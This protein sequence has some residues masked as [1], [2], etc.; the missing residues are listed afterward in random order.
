MRV[1]LD[2][3]TLLWWILDDPA[4][5]L[6]ASDAIAE[7]HDAVFVSAATAWELAIKF[8]LGR[9][10]MASDLIANFSN[11]VDNEKFRVLPISVDHGIRAG[12]LPLIHKDPFDRLLV[13]QAQAENVPIVSNDLIFEA[14]G[15]RRLW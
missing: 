9:L 10:P 15:V 4:L 6:R 7:A 13:A 14:Y 11:V 2:S 1:L 8:Q 5:T 12:T 3:H